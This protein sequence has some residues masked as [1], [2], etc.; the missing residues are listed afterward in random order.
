[1]TV[2]ERHRKP[3]K[4]LVKVTIGVLIGVAIGSAVGLLSVTEPYGTLFLAVIG[5]FFGGIVAANIITT[6]GWCMIAGALIGGFVAMLL[7]RIGKAAM[8]GVAPGALLGMIVGLALEATQK[9]PPQD[10]G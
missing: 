3:S 6:V 5:V 4:R 7:A 2:T 9:N 10:E 1:M 8:Y